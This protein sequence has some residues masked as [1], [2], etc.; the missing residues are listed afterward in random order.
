[1]KVLR[2]L[3]Y[4]VLV[5]AAILLI[6]SLLGAKSYEVKRSTVVQATSAEVWPYLSNLENMQPWSPWRRMDSTMVVTFNG[7]PGKVGSSYSWESPKMGKGQQTLTALD[8]NKRADY[9]LKFIMPMGESVSQ[10]YFTLADT[11]GGTKVTWGITGKNGFMSRVFSNFMNFDAMMGKDFE[12][13]LT[14]LKEEMAKNPM[15]GQATA[16]ISKGPFD[17]GKYLAVRKTITMAE[18]EEYFGKNFG[19]VMNALT[20]AGIQPTTA[21]SGLY[22]SWDEAKGTSDVAAGMGFTGDLAKLPE[23]SAVIEVPASE[24]VIMNYYGGYHGLGKAH[25]DIDAYLKANNLTQ[26]SPVIEEYLTDPGAEPDSTKWLTKIVYP[27]K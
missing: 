3:L 18:M 4:I 1:M 27:V 23:G 6:L 9:D 21:P 13:G 15:G 24:A 19:L 17:G 11:T 25:G 10:T 14:Y 7:D 22:Y 8:P 20:A 12:N 2:I 5:I 16:G 26:G